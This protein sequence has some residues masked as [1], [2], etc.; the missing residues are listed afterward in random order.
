MVY[1]CK[2]KQFNNCFLIF[3][4]HINLRP[5]MLLNMLGFI[6]YNHFVED[7]HGTFFFFC[8]ELFYFIFMMLF[9]VMFCSVI[10]IIRHV[11]VHVQ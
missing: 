9:G 8:C 4:L 7:E 2:D 1:C 3:D 6:F 11:H 5:W 10:Q